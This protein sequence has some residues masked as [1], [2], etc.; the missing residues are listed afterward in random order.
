MSLD[1]G[2]YI[3]TS[4]S[5]GGRP[6]GRSPIEDLSLLPK[7]V[8]VLPDG[9]AAPKV[10]PIVIL[11]GETLISYLTCRVLSRKAEVDTR[12][13]L[14]TLPQENIEAMFVLCSSKK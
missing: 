7:Q 6:V 3:I 9:V 4:P 5:F 11:I 8:Y 2:H 14:S 1:N 12:S 13:R 10:S